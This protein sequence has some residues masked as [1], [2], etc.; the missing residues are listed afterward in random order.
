MFTKMAL[1]SLFALMLWKPISG[2]LDHVKGS[3]ILGF[4]CAALGEL[5]FP[6]KSPLLLSDDRPLRRDNRLDFRK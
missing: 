5:V 6:D 4:A 2:H 3:K 1:A